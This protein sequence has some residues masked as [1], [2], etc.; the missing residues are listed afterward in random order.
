M[1]KMRE[2]LRNGPGETSVNMV[3]PAYVPKVD[4]KNGLQGAWGYVSLNAL[5]FKLQR[6]L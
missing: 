5:G 2:I 3:G 6:D 4:S 1:E